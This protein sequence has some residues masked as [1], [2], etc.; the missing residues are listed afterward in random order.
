MLKLHIMFLVVILSAVSGGAWADSVYKCRNPQGALVY[1]AIPCPKDAQVSSWAAKAAAAP[2][3]DKAAVNAGGSV[4]VLRQHPNGH[5]F[6]DG[7]INGKALTFVI[8][9]G[10]S[11][12]S[13][14]REMAMMAQI[15][16]RDNI[17][18]QTANGA[19]SACTAMIPKLEFGPFRIE[20]AP[21]VIAP[22]LSQPLFG[23]NV[24]SHFKIE[25]ENGEMR[26]SLER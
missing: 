22:N 1:Q 15:Y 17:L 2:Q 21:A 12:V 24:L 25:Q 26:I 6:M 3:P 19:A 8:D 9:T 5:Y 11:V 14:P 7:T 13:L 4:L 18:M 20:N 10:A 16:C 23:M